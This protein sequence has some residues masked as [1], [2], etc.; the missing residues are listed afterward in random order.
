MV[1]REIDWADDVLGT[2]HFSIGVYLYGFVRVR[3]R[4]ETFLKDKLP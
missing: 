3:V 2:V 4:G 1:H